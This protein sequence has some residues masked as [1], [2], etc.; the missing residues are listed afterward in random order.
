VTE[1]YVLRFL[2]LSESYLLPNIFFKVPPLKPEVAFLF[3]HLFPL[4]YFFNK[5]RLI[6]NSFLLLV[7]MTSKCLVVLD[8]S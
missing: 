2:K 1:H 5:E 6:R 7:Y 8:S 4:C 3:L